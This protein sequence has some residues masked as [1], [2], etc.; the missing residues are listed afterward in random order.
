[1]TGMMMSL[2]SD[3]TMAPKATPMITPTA[4]STTFPR[5]MIS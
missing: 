5:I 1:M 3:V 4:R 2:T